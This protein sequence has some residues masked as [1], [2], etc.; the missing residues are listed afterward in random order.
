[1]V[2]YQDFDGRNIYP[3]NLLLIN[4]SELNERS[5]K[6]KRCTSLWQKNSLPVLQFDL[7]DNLITKYKSLTEASYKT[8]FNLG[9]IAECRKGNIFQH[10]G[11]KWVPGTETFQ[12]KPEKKKNQVFNEYLWEKIGKPKTTKKNPIPVLNLSAETLPG[13]DWMPIEGL[14]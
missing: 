12:Q 5:Y 11:F 10:K 7:N 3:E 14:E 6:F 13:E 1:N 4:R 2:S 8:G 9:A